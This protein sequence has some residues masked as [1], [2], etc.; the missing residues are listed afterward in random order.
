MMPAFPHVLASTLLLCLPFQAEAQWCPAFG[1]EQVPREVTAS[2]T[3]ARAAEPGERMIVSGIVRRSD[4]RTAVPGVVIYAYQT[5]QRGR[6]LAMQVRPD[7]R[8]FTAGCV[9]GQ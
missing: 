4:G 8:P 2:A 3:L 7:W 5:N 1:P 6:T 9:A